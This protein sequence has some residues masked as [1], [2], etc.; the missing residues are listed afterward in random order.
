MSIDLPE[1][2][3]AQSDH[4]APMAVRLRSLL[5]GS[6]GDR[7]LLSELAAWAAGQVEDAI[8]CGITVSATKGTQRMGATSDELAKRMDAIQYVLEDGPCLSCIREQTVVRIAD[9]HADRRWLEFA[10]RG[11]REGVASS[12][13]VPMVVGSRVVGA[14]N[15]YSPRRDGLDEGSV[16]RAQVVAH[17]AGG[18]IALA[19]RLAEREAE[20]PRVDTASGPRSV[21]DQAVGII[22]ARQ[23]ITAEAAFEIL[24]AQSYHSRTML[25]ERADAVVAEVSVGPPAH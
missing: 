20:T 13:S 22:M 3:S 21:I 18:A 10:V 11:Q 6:D 15:L 24:R 16:D 4:H 2:E 7:S 25:G 12:L 5:L 19:I 23:Q 1:S 14:V 8:S 9:L 17:Q